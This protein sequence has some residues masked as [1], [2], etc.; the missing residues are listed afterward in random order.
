MDYYKILRKKMKTQQL[1]L[2]SAIGGITK[3]NQILL[4]KKVSEDKWSLPGGFQDLN[5]SIETTVL[6]EI[7]EELNIDAK[8]GEL[9]SVFSSPKWNTTFYDGSKIQQV[10]F[11]FRLIVD[12]SKANIVL[13]ESELVDHELFDLDKLPPNMPEC[14]VQ[15][16]E[17]LKNYKGKVFLH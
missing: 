1:I 12:L 9:I 5:E 13:Q 8:T 7:K 16:C 15:K 4:V 10:M 14:C 6:R 11:F 2:P 17:D 3:G